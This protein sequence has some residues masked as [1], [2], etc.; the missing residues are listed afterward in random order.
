[1]EEEPYSGSLAEK[2]DAEARDMDEERRVDALEEQGFKEGICKNC[3]DRTFVKVIK[4]VEMC[5]T[6]A[7]RYPEGMPF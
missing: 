4:G 5:R 6:C 7:E 1:M 3:V 2:I